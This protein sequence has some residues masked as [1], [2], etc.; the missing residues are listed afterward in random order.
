MVERGEDYDEK[1]EVIQINFTYG[2]MSNFQEKYQYLFDDKD[3]RIYE[4]KDKDG[5][6][7]VNNFKIYEFNMDYYMK[8]WYDKNEEMIEKY[9]FFIMMNL[10]LSD[11]EKISKKDK[12]IG[13][14][15][16]EI[17]RVNK[18]PKFIEYMLDEE[19]QRK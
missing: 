1:I 3:Y 9:K 14:Y 17:E 10:G 15:M 8:F 11:L 18:D 6:N 13:K 7:F 2:M 12:V 16:K 4:I 19:D 5:K